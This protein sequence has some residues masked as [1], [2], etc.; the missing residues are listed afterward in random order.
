MGHHSNQSAYLQGDPSASATEVFRT[1]LKLGLTS[2]GGPIAHLGYFYDELV[3]RRKWV[4]EATYADL[5]TLCQLLPGPTSSQVGFVIGLLKAGWRGAAAAW[6]GFTL[7]SALLLLAFANGATMITGRYGDA[8]V[9]GLKLVAFAMVTQA[10]LG[11][12][13]NLTPVIRC[14]FIAIGALSL[15]ILAGG[16]LGQIGAIVL[17][18]VLGLILC[19]TPTSVPVNVIAFG[20]SQRAGYVCIVVFAVLLAGLPLASSVS[21]DPLLAI[22]DAFYRSGAL[23]FGGGHVVL[24]LLQAEVV[25]TG[26]VSNEMFLAGYGAAQAV[27][28]PLFTFAAY[29]GATIQPE[30]FGILGATTA[31]V[32]VFAPGL[33]VIV[34]IMPFWDSWRLIPTAQAALR[35]ANA[36]VVGILTSVLYNTIMTS[37]I[38]RPQDIVIAGAALVALTVGRFAPVVVVSGVVAG[39]MFVELLRSSFGS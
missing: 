30:M 14:S 29:L 8:F 25:P 39:T 22:F 13:R 18:G 5:V 34:G 32:A 6:I 10:V 37:A 35:G 1:F 28:G 12:T 27:P 38:V 24:P 23:V 19:R 4:D 2:F 11:M 26:W 21:N 16:A 9:H 3:V 15:V 7:P 36:A 33:L 17:G 31:L 20:V